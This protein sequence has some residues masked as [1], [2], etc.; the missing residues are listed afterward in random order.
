PQIN[1]WFT[2]TFALS[3]TSPAINQ[4]GDSLAPNR[5][6]R[7]NFRNGQ[8][9]IGAF[10]YNGG[11]VGA[12]SIDRDGTSAA[13]SAELV[14]GYTYRLERKMNL[15]DSSWQDLSATVD[16]IQA[17]DNDVESISDP[18]GF[19]FPRAFYHIIVVQ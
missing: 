1:G 10:E 8:S 13:V 12:S 17:T 11:F 16:D 5:D 9:D 7:G 2:T 19:T 15:T 6:Q 4:G 14:V 3:S 18:D